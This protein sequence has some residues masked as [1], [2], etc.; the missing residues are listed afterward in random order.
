MGV[1]EDVHRDAV[2]RTTIIWPVYYRTEHRS[3]LKV[4]NGKGRYERLNSRGFFVL[5]TMWNWRVV[6]RM[7]YMAIMSGLRDSGVIWRFPMFS[8]PR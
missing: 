3:T 6:S 4:C 7:R 2:L 5:Y 1:N 8:G